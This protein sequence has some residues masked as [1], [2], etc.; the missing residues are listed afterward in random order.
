M[1][2][3]QWISLALAGM[4][5]SACGG[6]TPPS[7]ASPAA[8]QTPAAAETPATAEAAQPETPAETP[9]PAP[10]EAPAAVQWAVEPTI[11]A[12]NIDVLPMNRGNSNEM[13][14]N[15]PNL[16]Q[17]SGLC[18][19]ETGGLYGLIDYAGNVVV[20]AQYS[21]IRLGYNGRL[22]L[23]QDQ[24]NY[25]TLAADGSLTP[26]GDTAFVEVLGTA[27]NRVVYWVPERGTL[28][29]NAGADTWLEE[30]YSANVPIGVEVV[31]AVEDGCAAAWDGFVLTDGATPVN[32]TR[33]EK[34]G[35]YRC[36]LLPVRQNG[37]WGYI[38]AA[39][40][41]VL[42][43]EFETNWQFA[44]DDLSADYA[45]PYGASAGYIVVTKGGQDALYTVGGECVIDFGA[46]DALRPVYGDKLWACQDGQWGVLQLTA[47]LADLASYCTQ[48]PNVE[49]MPDTAE[50]RT[51]AADAD[52]GL[53][54]R[55]GPGTEYARLGSVPKGV[56]M[57]VQGTSTAVSGW[58][59]VDQGGWV[60]EEYVLP[61]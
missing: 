60:S 19:I 43:F 3:V 15:A 4:L 18:V 41:T 23:T 21:E 61:L 50:N 44:F 6:T 39:G 45:V 54:L 34:V 49:V 5:L 30:P 57:Q 38:N 28:Y 1:R 17:E 14:Y 42:P 48:A 59:Y 29:L 20:P 2:N 25:V 52:G 46:Y 10:T 35:G 58:L 37:A 53:V 16:H 24:L 55:A 31:T 27:P 11:T 22:A 26:L 47:G 51:V 36:G 13:D 8:T 12:D 32:D 56:R 9:Q 40:E 33:Y 7:S